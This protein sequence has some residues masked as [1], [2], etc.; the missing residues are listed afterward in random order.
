[1]KL[2]R[3][4]SRWVQWKKK[5]DSLNRLNKKYNVNWITFFPPIAKALK[6]PKNFFFKSLIGLNLKHNLLLTHNTL[7]YSLQIKLYIL[8][9]S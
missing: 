3:P 7:I 8:T 9:S 5:V 4:G 2:H 1:M 6:P